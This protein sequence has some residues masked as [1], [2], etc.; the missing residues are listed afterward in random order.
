MIQKN[1]N[2]NIAAWQFVLLTQITG[3]ITIIP[4][5]KYGL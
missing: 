1:D 2:A 3:L 5:M 4:V